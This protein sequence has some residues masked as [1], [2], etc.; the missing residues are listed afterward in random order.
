[1]RALGGAATVVLGFTGGR[2]VITHSAAGVVSF[3]VF[4][5][6]VA[7]LVVP[8]S[9]KLRPVPTLALGGY[10]ALLGFVGVGGVHNTRTGWFSLVWL[11]F[12]ALGL[13]L[14]LRVDQSPAVPR[15]GA[16]RVDAA[17]NEVPLRQVVIAYGL[18]LAFTAFGV[19]ITVLG[20]HRGAVVYEVLGVAAV[21]LAVG[22]VVRGAVLRRRRG[23]WGP[24]G[25]S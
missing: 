14:V 25:S 5:A 20:Y 19:I 23:Y 8:D 18:M 9:P 15:E 6:A 21:A 1:M 12:G 3:V 13:L 24:P 22:S 2:G 11:V 10:L 16:T 7:A 17:G 4:A